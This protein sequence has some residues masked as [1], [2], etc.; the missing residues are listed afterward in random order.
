MTARTL[1]LSGCC[2]VYVAAGP[3]PP[4][5]LPSSPDNATTA[6]EP[7][8][9]T[10]LGITP[11]S[12]GTTTNTGTPAQGSALE[13]PPGSRQNP[14]NVREP[15]GPGPPPSPPLAA[16]PARSPN[17]ISQQGH[18][19]SGNFSGMGGAPD[20]TVAEPLN[21]YTPILGSPK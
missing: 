14:P 9:I 13:R 19:M 4:A 5:A 2:L 15:L 11:N 7:H 8:T 12:L 6:L 20:A 1:V 3:P 18:T 10:H 16:G 17:E 21:P